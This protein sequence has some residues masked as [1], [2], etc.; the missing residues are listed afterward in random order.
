MLTHFAGVSYSTKT[1]PTP[2]S[3]CG[4]ETFSESVA[5]ALLVISIVLFVIVV[6]FC[7]TYCIARQNESQ[8]ARN[9][10]VVAKVGEAYPKL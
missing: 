10:G 1:H 6:L 5:I 2:S 4:S 8:L 9:D 7:I 3:A